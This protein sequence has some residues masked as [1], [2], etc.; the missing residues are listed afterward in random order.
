MGD[1]WDAIRFFAQLSV[2]FEAIYAGA[3]VE[4]PLERSDIGSEFWSETYTAHYHW[5]FAVNDEV[6]IYAAALDDPS[7]H[8][9]VASFN[10]ADPLSLPRARAIISAF[11]GVMALQRMKA[12]DA[13]RLVHDQTLVHCPNPR[14][15]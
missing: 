12:S 7:G 8:I 14:I 5:R 4:C 11:E 2:W 9:R 15:I 3:Q 10:P 6:T 1:Q 13:L